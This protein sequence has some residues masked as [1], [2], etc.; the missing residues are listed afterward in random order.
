MLA[1]RRC[2]N[3]IFKARLARIVAFSPWKMARSLG[4]P[5]D[6]GGLVQMTVVFQFQP[7]ILQGVGILNDLT[8]KK[9]QVCQRLRHDLVNG[10][11]K[12]PLV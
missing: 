11:Y 10:S 7:C 4:L 9:K 1:S 12:K 2:A 3:S 6:E 5:L 8:G